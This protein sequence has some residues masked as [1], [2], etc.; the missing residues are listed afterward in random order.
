MD[1]NPEILRY[2]EQADEAGRLL[3][4]PFQLEFART[5]ELIAERL[6][7]PPATVLDVGGGAGPYAF[8]LAGLGYETHLIDVV[9]RH[10]SQARERNETAPHRIAGCNV[11]DAR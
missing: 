1:L 3:I 2:Y 9:S 5:Q 8:W 6:P 4:G 7:P 11:G 10:V